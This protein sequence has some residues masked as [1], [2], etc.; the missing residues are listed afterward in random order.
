MTHLN[1][2]RSV[3]ERPELFSI[4]PIDYNT[5]TWTGNYFIEAH[6]Q[7][8]PYYI[9][10]PTTEVQEKPET[11]VPQ[12]RID[13]LSDLYGNQTLDLS[14]TAHINIISA[15]STLSFDFDEENGVLTL[16]DA[17]NEHVKYVPADRPGLQ[18]EDDPNT[19]LEES[20]THITT[21][22]ASV[23]ESYESNHRLTTDTNTMLWK[24][25]SAFDNLVHTSR[26][27]VQQAKIDATAAIIETLANISLLENSSMKPS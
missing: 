16:D 10:F 4:A 3:F 24:I 23:R 26:N 25:I 27:T 11:Y 21:A 13:R 22:L 1:I 17:F 5:I 18:R 8:K 14:D 12:A 19:D 2:I 15:T 7:D 6:T 20:L 9:Y